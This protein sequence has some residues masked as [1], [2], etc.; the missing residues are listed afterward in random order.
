MTS[1][2]CTCSFFAVVASGVDALRILVL[3]GLAV[4]ARCVDAGRGLVLGGLTVVAGYVDAR[5][6]LVLAGRALITEGVDALRSLELAGRALITEGVDAR[7]FLVLACRTIFTI[8][9]AC[10]R[11]FSCPTRITGNLTCCRLLL[12]CITILARTTLMNVVYF[13]CRALSAL[14][15]SCS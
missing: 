15:S 14:V 1:I 8:R 2:S 6:C 9:K 4:V 11:I 10:I 3:A 5:R 7:R 12:A 13:S